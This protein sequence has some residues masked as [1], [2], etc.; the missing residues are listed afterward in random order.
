MNLIAVSAGNYLKKYI[1]PGSTAPTAAEWS[2][3]HGAVL[4]GVAFGPGGS[5][6]CCG[7]RST[8]G[9]THHKVSSDGTLVWN[10]DHGAWAHH[11][12]VDS[13]GNCYVVGNTSSGVS[14]RKYDTDGNLLWSGGPNTTLYRV[15]LATDGYVYVSGTTAGGV[16]VW[17]YTT[18]LLYTSRCV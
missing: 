6:Y 11:L 17:R 14:L 2:F 8:A 18:C 12:A 15:V 9:Y 3:D 13:S 4:Y 5:I 16:N 7:I 1:D 10:A